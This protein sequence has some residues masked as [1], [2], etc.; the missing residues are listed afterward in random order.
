MVKSNRVQNKRA[1]YHLKPWKSKLDTQTGNPNFNIS[2]TEALGFS[3]SLVGF[4]KGLPIQDAVLLLQTRERQGVV[5][6]ML[7]CCCCCPVLNVATIHTP[8]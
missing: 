7:C 3:H 8:P 1:R 5:L 2:G 4:G 6:C